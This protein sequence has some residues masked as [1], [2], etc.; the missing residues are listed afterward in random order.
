MK[1]NALKYMKATQPRVTQ[2]N[3]KLKVEITR[4]LG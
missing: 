2:G 1:A 4:I 3:L